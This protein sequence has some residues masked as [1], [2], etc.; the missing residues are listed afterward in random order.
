[1]PSKKLIMYILFCIFIG[2]GGLTRLIKMDRTISAVV[3]LIL[4]VLIFTLF[5]LRW[6]GKDGGADSTTQWPPIVNMCPD[7]LTAFKHTKSDGTTEQVCI[8]TIGVS[9]NCQAMARWPENPV[10]EPQ[11]AK[12]YFSLEGTMEEKCKRAKDL[13]LTWEACD[14]FSPSGKPVDPSGSGCP[15]SS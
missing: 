9:R 15:A 2:L 8:D 5:G 4:V 10:P 3:Y 6:F 7:Y 13:G 14:I 12:Y 11:D 1:M